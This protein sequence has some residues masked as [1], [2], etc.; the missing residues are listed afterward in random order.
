MASAPFGYRAKPPSR[1]VLILDCKWIEINEMQCGRND[2][3]LFWLS[4][5]RHGM[6]A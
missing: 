6:L 3:E 1:K 2:E 5:N 4:E